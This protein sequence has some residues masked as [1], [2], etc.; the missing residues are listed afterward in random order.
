MARAARRINTSQR[1]Y[2]SD[3]LLL[4]LLCARSARRGARAITSH[5]ACAFEL[6]FRRA[7]IPLHKDLAYYFGAP[8]AV[9]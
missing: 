9:E 2:W 4:D 3:K 5:H 6:A 7:R 8:T 1:P